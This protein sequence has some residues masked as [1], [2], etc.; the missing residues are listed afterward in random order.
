MVNGHLEGHTLALSQAMAL[1]SSA[2]VEPKQPQSSLHLL[3]HPKSWFG[4]A[5]H[6][7]Q[8]IH[9]RQYFNEILNTQNLLHLSR[10]CKLSPKECDPRAS[11]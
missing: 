5:L 9:I 2:V 8:A 4:F 11:Q 7:N 6:A 10:G 1:F 3:I